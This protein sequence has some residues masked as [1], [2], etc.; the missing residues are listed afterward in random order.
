MVSFGAD[1]FQDAFILRGS[2][3]TASFICGIFICFD[4]SL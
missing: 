4:F 2:D 3:F 1:E